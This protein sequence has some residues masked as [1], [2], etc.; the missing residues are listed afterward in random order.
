LSGLV[1]ADPAKIGKS[2]DDLASGPGDFQGLAAP[3]DEKALRVVAALDQCEGDT[4]VL[5]TASDFSVLTPMIRDCL[6][7]KM[8]IIST[9]EQMA[10]P[11]YRHEAL[12]GEIDSE[13]KAAGVAVLG[14]GVNPGFGKDTLAVTL[15]SMVRRVTS[16]RCIRRLDAGLRRAP[17]QKKVGATLSVEKFNALAAENKLGHQGLAESVAMLGAGLGRRVEPGSVRETLE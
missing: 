15:A 8:S 5:C 4:A 2:L 14:T 17:L 1:D 9:C 12:A 16:V 11:W 7:R 13:A 6:A 3:A 10:W